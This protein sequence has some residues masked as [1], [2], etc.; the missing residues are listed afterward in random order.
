MNV[1]DVN[2]LRSLL[3]REREMREGEKR[4]IEMKLS[5][6]RT[7]HFIVESFDID[8]TSEFMQANFKHNL[9]RFYA[10]SFL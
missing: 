8:L 7:G 5:H 10:K 6:D 9:G 2:L 3:E 4:K 1:Q